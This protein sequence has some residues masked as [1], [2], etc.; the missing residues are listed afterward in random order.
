MVLSLLRDL[1]SS[2]G[3]VES[4]AEYPQSVRQLLKTYDAAQLRWEN[5]THRWAIVA[6]IL[7]RGSAHARQ[8]LASR[9][10]QHEVR[11]LARD[12]RG[13]GLNEPDRAKLR[14]ELSLSEAEVPSRPFI[15]FEG[16]GT[17]SSSKRQYLHIEA[18]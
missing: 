6:A 13:A 5:P 7:T 15:G 10:S 11:V 4:A 2:D 14:A 18:R 16:G 8:W 3:T 9:L 1:S 17:V 12:F